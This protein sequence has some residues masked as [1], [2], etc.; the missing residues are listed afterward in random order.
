MESKPCGRSPGMLYK[1]TRY[2][3]TATPRVQQNQI[4]KIKKIRRRSLGLHPA[5]DLGPV[6]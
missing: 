3:L 4:K 6:L 2:G 5:L 1:A